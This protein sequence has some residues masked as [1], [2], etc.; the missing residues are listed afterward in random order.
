MTSYYSFFTLFLQKELGFHQ[1]GY[2]WTLA[3]LC[4]IPVI[5]FSSAIIKRIGVRNLFALGICA[6]VVRLLGLSYVPNVYWVIPLQFLHAFTFGAFFS[7]S[8]HYLDQLIPHHMKQ[9]ATTILSSVAF[10]L[11]AILG[12]AFG[13][14]LVF[15]FGFRYMY[16][17]YSLVALAALLAHFIFVKDPKKK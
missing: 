12:S 3:T 13:G 16:R 11:P 2:L 1:A 9:S 5:F 10:G 17:C 7:A 8:I 6:T 4:E 14:E 15:N